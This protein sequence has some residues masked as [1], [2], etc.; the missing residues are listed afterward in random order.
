M[1]QLVKCPNLDLGSGHDLTVCEVE[2]HIG[3]CA[4]TEPAWDS[5]S[6]SL[7]LSAPPLLMV[8]M[9]TLSLSLKNKHLKNKYIFKN[10]LLF[11]LREWGRGRE[12][13]REG[14]S[15]AGSAPAVP[16]PVQGLNSQTMRS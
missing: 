6:L 14:E 3:L 13:K 8:R 11:I 16:S 5:V 4:N 2:P 9:R 1:A 7:P 10:V 12:R 15:R